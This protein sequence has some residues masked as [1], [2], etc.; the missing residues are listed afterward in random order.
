MG[1]KY[2][3]EWV[4]DATCSEAAMQFVTRDFSLTQIATKHAQGLSKLYLP[5]EI[6][7]IQSAAELLLSFLVEIEA[8]EDAAYY[9]SGFSFFRTNY[10]TSKIRRKLNSSF[11]AADAGTNHR[12]YNGA[13]ALKRFRAYV[14]SMRSGVEMPIS[15]GWSLSLLHELPHIAAISKNLTH[16]FGLD[17]SS[18]D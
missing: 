5:I 1:G 12:D 11:F 16:S 9:L 4:F 10:K 2:C 3:P 8:N 15:S 18:N 6:I 17:V 13:K 7:E 14:F